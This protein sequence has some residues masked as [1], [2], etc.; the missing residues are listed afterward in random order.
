MAYKV[1]KPLVITKR[2]DGSDLYLYEGALLPD[3][4]SDEEAKR[5]LDEEFVEKVGADEVPKDADVK[6]SVK[7][8]SKSGP[9]AP[10][11]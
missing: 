10:S 8:S 1:V 9:S 5:L 2:Q 11:N 6:T 4:V 3:F 7:G